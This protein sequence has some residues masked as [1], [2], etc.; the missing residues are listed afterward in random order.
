MNK[1]V[2]HRRNALAYGH[3]VSALR[4][5]AGAACL[6]ASSM[7]CSASGTS[8]SDGP[9]NDWPVS[10]ADARLLPSRSVAQGAARPQGGSEHL[11]ARGRVERLVVHP[12]G[13]RGEPGIH[14]EV[15]LSP[16]ATDPGSS[17]AAERT[18]WV[19]GGAL[20]HRRRVVT[21]V[22]QFALGQAVAMSLQ[23]DGAGQSW[24]V[25]DELHRGTGP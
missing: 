8:D 1:I 13:P 7:G 11:I 14:T 17:G 21:H 2:N 6:L 3:D 10:G 12:F 19:P 20:G 5:L 9:P 23:T 15:T 4:V 25:P 16:L 18:F 22:P 24:F